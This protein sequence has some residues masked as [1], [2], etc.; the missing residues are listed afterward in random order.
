[1][2]NEFLKDFSDYTLMDEIEARGI[3]VL[4]DCSDDE[5]AKEFMERNLHID[6]YVEKS[7]LG[8]VEKQIEALKERDYQL[9]WLIREIPYNPEKIR[10]FLEKYF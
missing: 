3:D 4:D 9:H 7:V 10:N 6:D 2:R 8:G 1:M 5:V